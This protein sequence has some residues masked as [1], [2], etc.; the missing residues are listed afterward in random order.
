MLRVTLVG[1]MGG[2][3]EL[4][5]S[6]KGAAIASFSVAVNQVRKGPDGER[7]ENTEWFR[8]R[9]G[10]PQTEFVQRLSKGTRVL[11]LGRLDISHY[12][13][14]DGEPRTGFDVWADDVQAMSS[15]SASFEPDGMPDAEGDREPA[16]AGVSSISEPSGGRANGNGPRPRSNSR[17]TASGADGGGQDLEDLP[18]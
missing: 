8:I 18:F 6:Q 17:P 14:R 13:S 5:Y 3:P 2:D 1:N 16:A 4:R 12:Q 15:R 7:Q 9:V 11:V 10:G